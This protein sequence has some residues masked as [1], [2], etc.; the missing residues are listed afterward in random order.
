[1]GMD[2]GSVDGFWKKEVYGCGMFFLVI[3]F[4]CMELVG[5]ANVM[6][7]RGLRGESDGMGGFLL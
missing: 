5:L 6:K 2:T 3:V 4:F 1:M 7:C